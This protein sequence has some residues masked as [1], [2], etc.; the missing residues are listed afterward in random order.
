MKGKGILVVGHDQ[1]EAARIIAEIYKDKIDIEV[2]EKTLEEI[3]EERRA[4]REQL[5][6]QARYLI[7]APEPITFHEY[8]K[9]PKK[10]Q[11]V[12]FHP[13]RTDPKV[14]RNS[15]CPCGSGKKVKYC[16]TSKK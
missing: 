15:P 7:K 6:N 2:V 1:A 3:E 12:V 13:I 9:V 4:E 11:G 10:M 5:E 16:C 14:G 8:H